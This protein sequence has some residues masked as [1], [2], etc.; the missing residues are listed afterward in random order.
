MTQELWLNLPVKDLQN[1]KVFFSELGFE[2]L[3]DAPEMIGF[4]IGGVSVLMVTETQF[5]K[6]ALNKVTDTTQ[7]NELLLSIGAPSKAFVDRMA[8]KVEEAG[9]KVISVPTVIQGWMYGFTFK[10]LDGHRWNYLFMD[11]DKMKQ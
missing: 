10:D 5:E 9:G 11:F 6:Y 4:K 7:G 1:T 8:S 3:R 2:K